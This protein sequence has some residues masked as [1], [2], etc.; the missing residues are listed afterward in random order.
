[1]G[2]GAVVKAY[3]VLMATCNGERFLDQQMASILGQTVLPERLLVADDHSSD[4]TLQRLQHWRERSPVPIAVLLPSGSERLGSCRNFERLLQAS[5]AAYVMLADQ[6]D[7]WDADK[8]ERLLHQMALLEQRWG[9][10][11]PLLVHADL[12]L[13]DAEGHPLG[14]SFHRL[15]GLQP[16]R[17]ALLDIGLQNVVTGCAS[18]LN[19]ACVR[20]ALPFPPEAVLHD[21]WLALVAA[22]ATGLVYLRGAC[23]SYRQHRSNVVGAAGWPRQLLRR[24]K[25]VFSQNPRAVLVELISPGLRQLRA[26]LVRYG[27]A[28]LAERC[29][30]LWSPSRWM[31]LRAAAR[32][33]LRKH[34]LWR[35]IGFYTALFCCR[36]AGH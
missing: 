33:G 36:P 22:Q 17:Q 34:G 3:E 8:A 6:D 4:Q 2:L 25:A 24:M 19:R 11:R 35:T 14:P 27:P 12:R 1:M 28:D 31:R 21:W 30:L 26:C 23:V 15:Q 7:L 13:I 32:L 9:V 16:T 5:S 29:Q 18:I 20:Q 10:E